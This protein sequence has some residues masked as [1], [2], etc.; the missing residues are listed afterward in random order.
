MLGDLQAHG[1]IELPF[2]LE[3]LLEVGHHELRHRNLQALL[4]DVLAVE[5]EKIGDT[6][7][8]EDRE[9][10]AGATPHIHHGFRLEEREN[11]GND[12]L[13][14]RPGPRLVELEKSCV[15]GTGHSVRQT[16]AADIA[17]LP[18]RT[19]LSNGQM[20]RLQSSRFRVLFATIRVGKVW[21]EPHEVI[22]PRLVRG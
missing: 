16:A 14:R 22:R 7:R 3:R 9:P 2:E 12:H 18:Y 5:P 1:Q 17:A 6:V 10:C 19:S 4:L 11:Q 13:G 15:V 21:P 8:L 20:S